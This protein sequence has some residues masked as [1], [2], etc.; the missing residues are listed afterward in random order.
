MNIQM[1]PLNRLVPSPANVRKVGIGID[2]I[3]NLTTIGTG[4]RNFHSLQDASAPL[5]DP[6]PQ[7]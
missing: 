2:G 4:L 7:R 5:S 3:V 1:I 6:F